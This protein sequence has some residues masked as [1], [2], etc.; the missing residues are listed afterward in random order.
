M[1]ILRRNTGENSNKVIVLKSFKLWL[2][3][4][5]ES[6]NRIWEEWTWIDLLKTRHLSNGKLL[7]LSA[8]GLRIIESWTPPGLRHPQPLQSTLTGVLIQ[9]Y[10]NNYYYFAFT[11]QCKMKH[12]CNKTLK[13]LLQL[14][15]LPFI[16]IDVYAS[17]L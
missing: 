12:F 8:P 4:K 13:G 11:G 16:G 1:A 2:F 9:Y 15:L 14:F 17:L 10:L 5:V 3:W 6:Y 7:E